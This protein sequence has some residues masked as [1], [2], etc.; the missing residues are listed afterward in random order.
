MDQ[1]LVPETDGEACSRPR[2]DQRVFATRE[3]CRELCVAKELGPVVPE[4]VRDLCGD[5]RT[6]YRNVVAISAPS[7]QSRRLHGVV[8]E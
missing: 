5:E 1:Q 8:A 7:A 6:E 4:L 2:A 3:H